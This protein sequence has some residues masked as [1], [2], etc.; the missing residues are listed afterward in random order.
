MFEGLYMG[1]PVA[2]KR[3]ENKQK[4]SFKA[5]LTEIEILQSFRGHPNVVL[6]FGGYR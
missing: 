4:H 3:Y 2:V 5:F 6:C 1:T